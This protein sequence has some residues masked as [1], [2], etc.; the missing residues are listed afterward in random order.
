[1]TVLADKVP[2]GFWPAIDKLDEVLP[3]L[4]HPEIRPLLEKIALLDPDAIRRVLPAWGPDRLAHTVSE[5]LPLKLDR[6]VQKVGDRWEGAAA[7]QFAKHMN[8]VIEVFQA[9]DNPAGEVAANIESFLD[10]LELSFLDMAG[11]VAGWLGL[12]VAVVGLIAAAIGTGTAATGGGVVLAAI[13]WVTTIVGMILGIAGIVISDAQYLEGQLSASLAGAREFRAEVARLEAM[14]PGGLVT[15]GGDWK[16][17][18]PEPE[19]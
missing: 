18:T 3:H 10:A 9:W 1:M 17:I 13:G 7:E 8:Q 16:P 12:I 15:P 5:E 19:S 11:K 6:V 2:A 4:G 14:R